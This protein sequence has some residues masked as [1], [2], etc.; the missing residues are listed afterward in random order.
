LRWS[1][2]AEQDAILFYQ[3]GAVQIFDLYEKLRQRAAIQHRS[4]SA[5]VIMI[6]RETL[7]QPKRTPGEI[8]ASIQKRRYFSPTSV[9]A[10]DSTTF[11]RQDRAR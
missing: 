7:D 11:L 2:A 5:E 3:A 10:P 4:L 8:L 6:L 9:G 1:A